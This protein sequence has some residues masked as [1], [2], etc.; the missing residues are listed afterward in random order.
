MEFR[1]IVIR[2]KELERLASFYSLF[3]LSFEYH[4][5]GNSPFHYSAKINNLI[6]EIY[7]LAKNQI[8]LDQN[9]RLGFAINNFEQTSAG[10]GISNKYDYVIC[11]HIHQPEIRQ[12]SNEDGAIT[13]LNSGDWIEN[14]TAL[15]YNKGEW[16]I[17]RFGDDELLDMV[18]H[19]DEVE[20]ELTK[21]QLFNNLLN[22]FKLM[23]R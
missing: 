18:L 5:H 14:L 11:G 9:L 13:Y 17:Y 10:I 21:D 16:S 1:L 3:G 22:E 6:I 4:K 23:A 12:M 7:P 20:T 15:E 8:E 2:T 19:G